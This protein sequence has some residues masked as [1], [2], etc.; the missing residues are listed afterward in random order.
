MKILFDV[1][2]DFQMLRNVKMSLFSL[3]SNST[4][5]RGNLV[6]IYRTL[7]VLDGLDGVK[8]FHTLSSKFSLMHF[9]KDNQ[10]VLK[11][12][13]LL[14]HSQLLKRVNN[15]KSINVVANCNQHF[16]IGL[17]GESSS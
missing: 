9:N 12:Y 16:K 15:S 10:H 2:R 5:M 13:L 11:L 4:P 1:F 8:M 17:T 14:A 3:L 7:T 6:E